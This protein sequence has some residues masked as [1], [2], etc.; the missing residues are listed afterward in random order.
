MRKR[1]DTNVYE[2]KVKP[3]VVGWFADR[4]QRELEELAGDVVPLTALRTVGEVVD[5]PG[6]AE[7][8]MIVEADYGDLGRLRMFGQPIKLSE[9]PAVADRVANRLGEHTDAVLTELAGYSAD[10][11]D[12]LRGRGVV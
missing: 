11:I 2:R 5:D 1:F 6:T 12:D 9:T 10:R 4:T 7:R 8:D 3:L